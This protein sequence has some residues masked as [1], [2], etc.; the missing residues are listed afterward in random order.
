MSVLV[1]GGAG[2]I[3]SHTVVELLNTG[4]DVIVVDNFSNSNPESLFR[5][6]EITGKDFKVYNLSILDRE[7][8]EKIFLDN[9]IQAV[10]HFAGLKAVGESVEQPLKY[11]IN[12]ISGTLILCEVMQKYEVK[13]LVFSSSATVYGLPKALPISED[14]PLNATNP[15]G[16]SKLIVEEILEDLFNSDKEWSI[17][18]LRYFNPIGA[19]ESGKIG[20]DPIG[21]PNN[22]L[23]FITKVAAG[24]LKELK[25]FGGDY[26]TKDGTGVRDYI[27][28]V[29]LA[30][31]H[32]K[33]LEKILF[34]K[35][36]HIYN[37]GTGSGY[38]VLQIIASFE[39][40]CG[41]TIPYTIGE[42]RPGDVSACYANPL[43]AKSEL[44]WSTMRGIEEMCADSWRW[45]LNSKKD[46]KKIKTIFAE[47][48]NP[49]LLKSKRDFLL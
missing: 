2:Y 43:K 47:M 48:E 8:L 36:V 13:K 16:R 12:N 7:G 23:P 25:V 21:V 32:I 27:H 11:Y 17:S 29:D 31:G 49:Y 39:K 38:S 45:Q 10:I 22:L 14:F 33:A 5:I 46:Y 37:L 44:N 1:T 4:N 18:I 30:M 19:H 15:Y 24:E 20:E 28:V 40:T 3:G 35:G 6:S 34:T 42:R 9:N 41:K 26:P